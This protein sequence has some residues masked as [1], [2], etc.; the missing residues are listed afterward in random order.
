MIRSSLNRAGIASLAASALSWGLFA[1][2]RLPK[3]IPDPGGAMWVFPALPWLAGAFVLAVTGVMALFALQRRFLLHRGLPDGDASR[4]AAGC[5]L[6]S[7][8][9]LLVPSA[10]AWSG[11]PGAL[12]LCQEAWPMFGLAALGMTAGLTLA[13]APAAKRTGQALKWPGPLVLLIALATFGLS[14]QQIYRANQSGPLWGGDEPQYLYIAHSLA[15]DHD[16]DL[17]NQIMLREN[18]SYQ[19]PQDMIG[20]HGRPSAGGIWLSKHM[21]GLPLLLS[22]FYAWGLALGLNPRWLCALAMAL[23]SAW[24]VWEAFTLAK[25]LTGRYWAAFWAASLSALCLP[26]L[27]YAPSIFPGVA[28]AAFGLASFRRIERGGGL[29]GLFLAG[30]MAAYLP[31]LNERFILLS[32]IL[33]LYFLARG[34]WRRPSA[35]AAFSLP[36]LASALAMMTYF[37]IHW[38]SVLPPVGFHA[39]GHFLN[40]R[41][42]WQGLVG[43][44]LDGREG[45]LIYAPVWL[46]G[47]AGL[48]WLAR[49]SGKR[50]WFAILFFLAAWLVA[51]PYAEWWGGL[52]PPG[53]Y[54]LAAAPFLAL[55][56]AAGLAGAGP[57]FAVTALVLGVASL[58]VSGQALDQVR[59]VVGGVAG[60]APFW[61]QS[62]VWPL[63]SALLPALVPPGGLRGAALP[64]A[65][66][67]VIKAAVWSLTALAGLAWLLLCKKKPGRAVCALGMCGAFMLIILAA[68]AAGPG[69][70]NK[71]WQLSRAQKLNLWQ[72][73][74]RAGDVSAPR[75]KK[76]AAL[77]IRLDPAALA[78]APAKPLEEGKALIPAGDSSGPLL[79]GEYLDLPAGRYRVTALCRAGDNGQGPLAGLDVAARQGRLILAKAEVKGGQGPA[80]AGLEFA[81]A[82]PLKQVEIRLYGAGRK[83]VVAGL[84]LERLL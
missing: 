82:E 59:Q 20:G 36:L 17:Y 28:G 9:L 16:L 5:W 34:H 75:A 77:T 37:Y 50:G 33:G 26:L 12:A 79:W 23:C 54:L 8:A 47:L 22:P 68:G 60:H 62:L 53:R 74:N 78:H 35:L 66:G 40:Q 57:G 67:E 80:K 2:T 1:A 21:P 38:G 83:V 42:A 41:G 19:S 76:P 18:I 73:L 46:T 51:G 48:G 6:P 24:L 13:H 11:L 4:L 10:E 44:L 65:E 84:A 27:I 56:L 30:L 39:A 32:L 49:Y 29:G 81:L 15:V 58:W 52:C 71:V 61:Q 63:Q 3:A 64:L 25:S 14:A 55:G 45:L 70:G 7:L 69:Y 72:R 43:L 31:W